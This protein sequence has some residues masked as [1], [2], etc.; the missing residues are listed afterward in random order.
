VPEWRQGRVRHSRQTLVR[1]RVFQIVC[2]YED[3]DDADMLRTDPLLKLVCGRGPELEVDLASQP[4]L[5][6]LENA[7]NARACYRLA[8]GLLGVYLQ[9]RERASGGPPTHLLLDLDGTDD[10]THGAQEGSTYH[11]Y[12]QQHMYHPLLIFD[13]DTGQLL[14]AVLRPGTMHA[15]RGAVTVLTRLVQRVRAR[16]PAVQIELRADSGFAMPA[17][18]D[19]CEAEGIAYTLGLSTNGA[20]ERRSRAV[21]RAGRTAARAHGGEGPL[22]GRDD[23]CGRQLAPAMPPRLQGRGAGTRAQCPLRGHHPRG[24]SARALQLVRPAWYAGAVDQ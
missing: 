19:W 3:Q 6:R 17:L 15:S 9:E 1:Q 12:Y 22:G 11:G 4:T 14:M 13:G 16:W 10:P 18:Y 21:A 2:G 8:E 23:L 7:V 20:A 24:H 5:S